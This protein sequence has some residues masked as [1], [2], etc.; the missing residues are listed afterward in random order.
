MSMRPVGLSSFLPLAIIA[1]LLAALATPVSAD[2]RSLPSN[3]FGLWCSTGKVGKVARYARGG[4][5]KK[6]GNDNYI[7]IRAGS[8]E[9]GHEWGCN[10]R[11]IVVAGQTYKVSSKCGGEGMLSDQEDTF[12]LEG[13]FLL[14]RHDQTSNERPELTPL[15]CRDHRSMPPDTDPDP[16]VWTILN[17]GDGFAVT[18]IT[19]SGKTYARAAQYRDI[20]V[21]TNDMGTPYWSGVWK[22]DHNKRMTGS[23]P[24]ESDATRYVEETYD[25]GRLAV[26]MSSK[27]EKE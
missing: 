13:P 6:Q 14:Y 25:G 20:H 12:W 2:S 7:E 15:V 21:W 26:T 10:I 11:K 27:C 24:Y 19:R 8:I 1:A 5:C 18:H 23:L 22:R 4:K 16:V 9:E 17:F 3:M